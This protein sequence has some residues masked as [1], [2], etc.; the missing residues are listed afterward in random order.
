MTI[1]RKPTLLFPLTGLTLAQQPLPFLDM[2]LH[3]LTADD[4]TAPPRGRLDR[5]LPCRRRPGILGPS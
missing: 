5:V 3:A 4:A 1:V 2:H